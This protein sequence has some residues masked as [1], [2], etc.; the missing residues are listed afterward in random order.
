M[1]K[2]LF[3]LIVLILCLSL[4][5]Y[6]GWHYFYG[7]RSLATLARLQAEASELQAK[8]ETASAARKALDAKVALLRPEHIDPDMLDEAVRHTLNYGGPNDLVIYIK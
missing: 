6:L 2:R 4:Y 1:R 7:S 5:G 3:D 8:L